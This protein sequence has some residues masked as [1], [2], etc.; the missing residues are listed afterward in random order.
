MKRL[1]DLTAAATGLVVLSPLLIAVAVA[2]WLQDF[3]SPFYVAPRMGLG[4]TTFKMVKFRSMTV[5]ADRAGVDSTSVDDVRITAIGRW[6]RAYKLDELMQLW[7]V[8][9]GD[10]SPVGP[11]P[12]VC[13]EVDIW[14]DVE[15]GL[16]SVKPGITDLSS[17]VFSD[18]SEILKGAC[19][20]DIAYN[21]LIRP[22]KS[23][24]GLAYIRHQSVSLDIE[25][26]LTTALALVSRRRA[27]AHVQR[28][29][30]RLGVDEQT[31][32][33]ASRTAPLRPYPPPG[34]TAIVTGR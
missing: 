32:E 9:T 15:R 20:P 21:Q 29:L 33:A 24:L 16:L 18:E 25:L 3:Q 27:L 13:R 10:M 1:L 4:G 14:T 28:I 5:G 34:A 19:D 17:I 23:R 26:I 12:Q 6:L 11:R 30:A 2:V 8:L 7:N 22:W 31:R